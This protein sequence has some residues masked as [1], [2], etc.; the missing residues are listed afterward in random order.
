MLNSRYL[1]ANLS[2]FSTY[3]TQLMGIATLMIIICHANAY[4]VLLPIFLAS[5]LRWGNLGVDIFLFLSGLGA[6][7]SLRKHD[8]HN[9]DGFTSYYKKRFYRILL[10]YFIVYVPYCLIF[11]LLGKYSLGDS[12]LCLST[13]EYWLFHRGAW[14]VSMILVL[15]LVAPFLYKALSNNYKW[16]IAIGI[17]IALVILCNIP[18]KDNSSNSIL[19]NIQWTFNRGPNFILGLTTGFSCKDGK[20]FSALQVMLFSLASIVISVS[21]GVWKCTWLIVPIMLYF[22]ILLIKLLENTW[23]DRSLKLL[24]EISLES[25]LTN[26]TLKSLLGTII[27]VYF[28]T[29]V[30]YGHYLDYSIVIVAGLLLAYYIHIVVLRIFNNTLAYPSKLS[31]D[32]KTV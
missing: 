26:I 12:F 13:L 4:H 9:K 5:L 24:G 18:I 31:V 3:R 11:M 23:M 15:Y 17:I 1:N 21:I 10:P 19:H 20:Q 27:P 6:Y 32:K 28:T 29:S 16:L 25:Y 22:S 8:L 7:Y 30:F 14:F 2:D